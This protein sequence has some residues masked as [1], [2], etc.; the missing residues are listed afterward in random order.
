M[1]FNINY[2][3]IVAT[4]LAFCLLVLTACSEGAPTDVLNKNDLTYKQIVNTGIANSCPQLGDIRRGSIELETGVTY[5]IT[6]FCIE[7]KEYFVKEEARNK[8]RDAE[9]VQAQLLTRYTSSLEQM[10]GSV[11]AAA[12][13]NLVLTEEEGIDFQNIT[14]KLPGGEEVPFFF[15]IKNL[16]AT[17]QGGSSIDSSTDFVGEFNVPSYRGSNFL[18]PK[19]RGV[20]SGYD[21]AVALPANAD[22]DELTR[23]NVKQLVSGKGEIS[24]QVSKVN[25]E[26][27]EITGTF[28]SDQ[29]SATDLGAEDPED[30][31][32]KGIFYAIVNS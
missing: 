8:R 22:V 11:T 19:G 31:R 6:D 4:V 28:I 17:A 30:V 1:M 32:I 13:G 16:V 2:R 5:T 12:D 25:S 23:A 14:V 10:T 15:T 20:A 21:N 29:P 9:F 26:T 7:P 24:L 3:G 18:D 27:G